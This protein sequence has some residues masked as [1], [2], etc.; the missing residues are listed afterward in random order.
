MVG[1]VNAAGVDPG[2]CDTIFLRPLGAEAN[3]V[4]TSLASPYGS[5]NFGKSHFFVIVDGPNVGKNRIGRS[6]MVGEIVRQPDC[7]LLVVVQQPPS[8]DI[9]VNENIRM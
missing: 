7:A 3:L 5:L 1:L 4:I 9:K 6:F 2:V 8:S